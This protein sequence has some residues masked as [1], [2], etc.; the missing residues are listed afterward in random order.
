MTGP[1]GDIVAVPDIVGV[2]VST[3]V[4]CGVEGAGGVL[5]LRVV[6]VGATKSVD[7]TVVTVADVVTGDVD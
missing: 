3:M 2:A 5:V 6:V 1:R 7:E 4:V